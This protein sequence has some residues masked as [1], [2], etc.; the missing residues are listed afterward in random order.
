[1]LFHFA[2]AETSGKFSAIAVPKLKFA[3]ENAA[4]RLSLR[5]GEGGKHHTRDH[6]STT[7]KKPTT[8]PTTTRACLPNLY[9]SNARHFPALP[10]HFRSFFRSRGNGNRL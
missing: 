6:S 8:K 7:R 1:M 10:C 4:L 5:E 2:Q 9:S 3:V